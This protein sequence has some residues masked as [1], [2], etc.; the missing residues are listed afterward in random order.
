MKRKLTALL[1]TAMLAV[2]FAAC[3]KDD[4]NSN[5]KSGNSN[6]SS[7]STEASKDASADGD[8]SAASDD[9]DTTASTTDNS[10]APAANYEVDD[11]IKKQLDANL[12][13]EIISENAKAAFQKFA[14]KELDIAATLRI[15]QPDAT[16]MQDVSVKIGFA[17]NGNNDIRANVEVSGFA[18]DYLM[19]GGESYFLDATEKAAIHMP[20]SDTAAQEVSLESTP[21]SSAASSIPTDALKK[22]DSGDE[23][24]N[25]EKCSFESYTIDASKISLPMSGLSNTSAEDATLNLKIYYSGYD[26]KGFVI[27]NSKTKMTL[28][29]DKFDTA[30]DASK[31]DIPADYET[32][33]DDGSYMM[34]LLMPLMAMSSNSSNTGD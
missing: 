5:S 11:N 20:K 9:K 23:D 12:T 3:N 17:K 10:A 6:S 4:N 15:E 1:L 14:A 27:E 18:L 24:F 13:D 2:S 34:N 33:E 21:D 7:A 22:G 28:T 32:K 16:A 19:K 8:K 29:I 31:F 30:A 25:G 26:F